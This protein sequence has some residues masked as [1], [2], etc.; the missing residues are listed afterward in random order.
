MVQSQPR[1]IAYKTLSGK[2]LLQ[3]SAGGVAQ[4]IGPEYKL[5]HGEKKPEE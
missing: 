1:Q 4:G 2:N 3:K 5:Q